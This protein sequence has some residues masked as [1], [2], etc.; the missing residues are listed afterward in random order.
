M[1]R[2]VH[3]CKLRPDTALYSCMLPGLMAA[4]CIL[5]SVAAI[6]HPNTHRVKE[7]DLIFT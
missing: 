5:Q 6:S 2:E 4:L 7:H 1:A 3:G